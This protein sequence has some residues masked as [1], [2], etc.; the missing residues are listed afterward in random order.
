MEG[1]ET[2]EKSMKRERPSGRDREEERDRLSDL[3]DCVLLHILKFMDTKYAVQTCVLSQRW[4]NLWKCLTN[5]KFDRNHFRKT[6]IFTKFV[7]SVLC[8]RNDSISLHSLDFLCRGFVDP[9]FLNWIMR[10]AVLHKI[11]QLTMH[12]Y[13]HSYIRGPEFEFIPFIFSCTSLTSLKVFIRHKSGMIKLPKSLQLPA[14]KSLHLKHVIFTASNH[15]CA[16]PFSTCKMLNTLVIEGCSLDDGVKVLCISNYNLSSLTICNNYRLSS[17]ENDIITLSIP[18]L[19]SLTIM[20]APIYQ[21]SFACNLPFLEEVNIDTSYFTHPHNTDIVFI[22][23]LQVLANVK[24]MT[25]SCFTLKE[26]L[27]ELLNHSSKTI[28]P[29]CFIK[30]ELLKVTK[31]SFAIISDDEVIWIVYYLLQNSPLPRIDV[32][33]C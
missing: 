16:E 1:I 22:S 27:H 33:N 10:Y 14:L 24:I 23:W 7:S 31:H 32:I 6:A 15:D 18:N 26:I 21:L 5:L 8:S 3:P 30:L 28:Q 12:I 19:N 11:Q 25:L 17:F 2:E 20:R 4:K 13:I 29:P 9:I